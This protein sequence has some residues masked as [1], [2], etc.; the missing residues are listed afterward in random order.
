MSKFGE[1][2]DFNFPV[3]L[4][5]YTEWSEGSIEMEPVLRDVAT[6]LGEKGKVIQ[7]DVDK[8]DEI[9]NAL[10]IKTLPTFIIY[11]DGEIIWR[12]SGVQDASTLI[13]LMQQYA[14]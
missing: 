2:I 4:D 12:Q 11:K 8:N 7:I 1:L 14:S 6:A 13:D 10:H 3:L 9:A 5:F